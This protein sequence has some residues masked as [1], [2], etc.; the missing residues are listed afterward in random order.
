MRSDRSWGCAFEIQLHTFCFLFSWLLRSN[1]RDAAGLEAVVNALKSHVSSSHPVFF[2]IYFVILSLSASRMHRNYYSTG[3]LGYSFVVSSSP[4]FPSST[5]RTLLPAIK[6]INKKYRATSL[7][8]K[9]TNLSMSQWSQEVAFVIDDSHGRSRLVV[10][11]L[12]SLLVRFSILSFV[13]SF[14]NIS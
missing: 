10:S 5:R 4:V 9:P 13:V 3:F 8:R 11:S 7:N 6:Y 1:R 14:I 12:F 2:P